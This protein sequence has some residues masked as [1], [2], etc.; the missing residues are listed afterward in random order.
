[1]A[2]SSS[3]SGSATTSSKKRAYS[4]L[5]IE[6]LYPADLDVEATRDLAIE[7][8]GDDV[9]RL[10]P[11]VRMMREQ[12]WL[13]EALGNYCYDKFRDTEPC[14]VCQKEITAKQSLYLDDAKHSRF[15]YG[16]ECRYTICVDCALK[17]TKCPKCQDAVDTCWIGGTSPHIM[18]AD[19]RSDK[20]KYLR[21][22]LDPDSTMVSELLK[23]L[24]V[25]P[26]DVL[27]LDG[28]SHPGN[29][30]FTISEWRNLARYNMLVIKRTSK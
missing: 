8:I 11:L 30:G 1:M 3:S 9:Q 5:E 4:I 26:A 7:Q 27:S 19:L 2:E 25:T 20:D 23:Q 29:E 24:Q 21:F 14:L 12:A 16:A 22:E 15:Q 10:A 28:F 6:A 13:C 18:V 17:C